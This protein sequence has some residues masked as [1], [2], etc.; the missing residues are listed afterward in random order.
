MYRRIP[1]RSSPNAPTAPR[2]MSSLQGFWSLGG[3]IGAAFSSVLLRQHA[4]ARQDLAAAAVAMIVTVLVSRPY[5]L[6]ED[7]PVDPPTGWAL[8]PR[9]LWTLAAVAFLSLFI[10]GAIGDWGTVYLRSTLHRL[11]G[12]RRHRLRSFFAVD[13]DRL[14]RRRLSQHEIWGNEVAAGFWSSGRCRLWVRTPGNDLCRGD[15]WF[16]GRRFWHL[17]HDCADFWCG[18][19][20]ESWRRRSSDRGCIERR[21]FGLSG[22]TAVGGICLWSAWPARRPDAGGCGR[23]DHRPC[24]A[25]GYGL[26]FRIR[27]CRRPRG[28]PQIPGVHSKIIKIRGIPH[29]AKNERD[30]GHPGS[31]AGKSQT[32]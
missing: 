16:A 15:D 13:D 29:L 12:N 28:K 5:L 3:V 31:A 27:P 6:E 22:W 19:A 7:K 2:C 23:S 20:E 9:T 32:A 17:Q 25:Q 30:M 8:I 26:T 21:L 10:E 4:T 24:G 18:G 11:S 14:L 1:R